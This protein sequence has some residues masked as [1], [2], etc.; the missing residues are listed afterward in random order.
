MDTTATTQMGRVGLWT[1][2]IAVLL[3]LIDGA[4][5]LGLNTPLA[6]SFGGATVVG[7]TEI[8]LALIA[9][10]ILYYYKSHPAAVAGTVGTLAFIGYFFDGGLYY[11]G[12][13]L[14]IIGA[15]LIYYRK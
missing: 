11:V 5:V 6:P 4:V 3:G 1:V 9:G 14:A 7:W 8:I 2:I 13:T 15:I 10:G 12:A